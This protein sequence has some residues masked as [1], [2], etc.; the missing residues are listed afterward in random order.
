[1]VEH[2]NLLTAV[3]AGLL[4]SNV[5]A[6]GPGKAGEMSLIPESIAI[7]LAALLLYCAIAAC[8]E[9]ASRRCSHYLRY[10]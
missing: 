8:A 7:F 1:M 10:R 6:W 2:S 4:V 3:V 5:H 9:A